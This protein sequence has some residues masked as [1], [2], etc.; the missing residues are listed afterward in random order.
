MGV[1]VEELTVHRDPRGAVFE[2]IDGEQLSGQR[3][4]HVV[5]TEPGGIRGNHSHRRGTEIITVCGPMLARY[6]EDGATRDVIVAEGQVIRLR[7]PPGVPHAFRNIGARPNILVAFN[8]ERHDREA[9]DVERVL[10]I[11]E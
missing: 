7:V 8:T 10:L 11:S 1:V 9:P 3:N 6:T 5:V 4:V 2:P